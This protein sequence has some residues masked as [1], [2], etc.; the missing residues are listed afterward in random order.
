MNVFAEV[1]LGEIAKAISLA[2]FG[3]E[4]STRKT[5]QRSAGAAV[6]VGITIVVEEDEHTCISAIIE[7]APAHEPRNRRE[8]E[9]GVITI[10]T[11]T[12]TSSK[13]ALTRSITQST[14][15]ICCLIS[16]CRPIRIWS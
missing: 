4:K 16:S 15:I 5:D 13:Q 1:R 11:T 10:P 6:V 14:T 9:V 7:V 3:R 12:S 8:R 2:P